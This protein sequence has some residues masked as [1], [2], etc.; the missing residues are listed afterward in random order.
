MRISKQYSIFLVATKRISPDL[1]FQTLH[2]TTFYTT[3]RN[4]HLTMTLTR[5][6]S[7]L[8]PRRWRVSRDQYPWMKKCGS[9]WTRSQWLLIGYTVWRHNY[10]ISVSN[11]RGPNSKSSKL[12]AP[13]RRPL[14]L[15]ESRRSASWNELP[16]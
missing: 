2:N 10:T 7:G 3:M 12:L 6:H 11:S 9:P 8:I 1:A 4:S 5:N 14:L 16:I 15:Q 13:H